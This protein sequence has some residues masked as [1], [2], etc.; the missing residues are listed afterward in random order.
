MAMND[1]T[2][3]VLIYNGK[4]YAVGLLWFT[5]QEESGKDLL[6]SRVKKTHADFY[7]QRLHISQQQAFGWLKQGH[8]RGMA[9]AAAMV[10]DQLVG[11]WHGVFEADNGWWYVQV[12][13]DTITPTGDRFFTTEEEAF[14]MFQDEMAKHNWPHAYAP[15]KWRL[16]DRGI[17]ELPL[18]TLL[19]DLVTS[20]L[21]PAN[22]TA[23]FGS[24]ATRNLVLGG[25]GVT[26]VIMAALTMYTVFLK[27][28]PPQ[29]VQRIPIAQIMAMRNAQSAIQ[30]ISPQ[31]LGQSCGD[32]ADKLYQSL[33]G[34]R[35]VKFTCSSANATMVWQQVTGSLGDAKE[36]GAKFWPSDAKITF[37]N[38]SLNVMAAVGKL[39]TVEATDLVNQED[40]LLYL[41]QELKPMGALQVNATIP[42]PPAPVARSSF[43]NNSPLPPPPK[44]APAYLTV[45]FKSGFAPE[46]IAPLL[47]RPGL[48]LQQLE[49][50]I[51]QAMWEYKIKW[52]FRTAKPAVPVTPAAAVPAVVPGVTPSATTTPSAAPSVSAPAAVQG[53][54]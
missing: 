12:R 11:E 28:P 19:D 41:E 30:I 39:P 5:V 37:A 3:G 7:C 40:A 20:S 53:V 27:A 51:P 18:K 49:W 23:V 13:S 6:Q 9:V 45:T 10:A 26:F 48:E 42:P 21:T 2:P 1:N 52:Y 50:Q 35:A 16:G 4:S 46:K 33:S 15:D 14:H 8:R 34:W 31:Q 29:P 54:K 24:V 38:R 47:L 25:L 22:V 32:H 43:L 17:R 44:P 36:H